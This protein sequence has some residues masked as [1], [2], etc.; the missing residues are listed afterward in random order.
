MCLTR[1]RA[2]KEQTSSSNSNILRTT[3]SPAASHSFRYQKQ[4]RERMLVTY[5]CANATE[6]LR[7][8]FVGPRVF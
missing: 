3:S 2:G 4:D 8:T 5:M 1:C 6:K 7:Q